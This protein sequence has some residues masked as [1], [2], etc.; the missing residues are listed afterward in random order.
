M[1]FD[2]DVAQLK[3]SPPTRH[4]CQPGLSAVNERVERDAQRVLNNE[5]LQSARQ[6]TMELILPFVPEKVV[7]RLHHEQTPTHDQSRY[8]LAICLPN[9]ILQLIAFPSSSSMFPDEGEVRL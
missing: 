3:G 1:F 4:Y 2:D 7:Q 9:L 5:D 6:C 8:W